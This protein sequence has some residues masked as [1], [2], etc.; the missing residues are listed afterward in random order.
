M[1]ARE[2]IHTQF[3]KDRRKEIVVVLFCSGPEP[4]PEL[5]VSYCRTFAQKRL[6]WLKVDR[7]NCFFLLIEA[8]SHI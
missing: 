6:Q 7:F 1:N 2:L 8:G 3:A 5:L 4:E